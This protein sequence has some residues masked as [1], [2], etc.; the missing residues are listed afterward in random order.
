[1]KRVFIALLGMAL[2]IVGC[3]SDPVKEDLETYVND[4]I[5]PLAADEEEIIDLYENV[6]G[7]NYTDDFIVYETKQ[8]KKIY[9][10]NTE[11]SWII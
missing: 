3:F 10:L 4:A 1:M 6:T 7:Y 9:C 5:I 8:Y 2:F 11:Y